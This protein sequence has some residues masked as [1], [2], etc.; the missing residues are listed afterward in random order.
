MNYEANSSLDIYAQLRKQTKHHVM[1]RSF[2][3]SVY[4][5]RQ[6]ELKLALCYIY[7]QLN[8]LK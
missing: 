1:P 3:T 4:N 6:L 5:R 2:L 8:Y 7:V